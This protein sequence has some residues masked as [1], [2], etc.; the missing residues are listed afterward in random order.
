MEIKTALRFHLGPI[1][2]AKIKKTIVTNTVEHLKTREP[3]QWGKLYLLLLEAEIPT[4][5]GNHC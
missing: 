2:M 5:I 4:G 1:K 3:L